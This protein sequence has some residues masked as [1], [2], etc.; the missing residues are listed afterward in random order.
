[1]DACCRMC[2]W[3]KTLNKEG[4][5]FRQG[6]QCGMLRKWFSFARSLEGTERLKTVT[7]G[8][9]RGEFEAAVTDP[10]VWEQASP[11]TILD[12]LDVL[13]EKKWGCR[14]LTKAAFPSILSIIPCLTHD[15]ISRLVK[16]THALQM[17]R[18]PVPS[19]DHTPPI[20]APHRIGGGLTT[21]SAE[22]VWNAITLRLSHGDALSVTEWV[23]LYEMFQ[24]KLATTCIDEN[25]GFAAQICRA[26]AERIPDLLLRLP[27]TQRVS[28][29]LLLIEVAGV[30][31]DASLTASLLVVLRKDLSSI[32]S[33]ST[34]NLVHVLL[35]AARHLK[36]GGQPPME[37]LR[38]GLLLVEASLRRQ[39]SASVVNESDDVDSDVL[40]AILRMPHRPQ[41]ETLVFAAFHQWKVADLDTSQVVEL[42][43]HV[44]ASAQLISVELPPQF[45][46]FITA[47]LFLSVQELDAE[48]CCDCLE[49][50]SCVEAASNA[51]MSPITSK[52]VSRFFVTFRREC[53][54]MARQ[55]DADPLRILERFACCC[56][57]HPSWGADSKSAAK[58]LLQDMSRCTWWKSGDRQSR[59]V[60][61]TWFDR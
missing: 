55:L 12:V 20:V 41:T 24:P 48:T 35:A 30:G 29:L 61:E 56:S 60:V 10:R 37:L 34:T 4:Q 2:S 51:S 46:D 5:G 39:S 13:A 36:E 50:L 26:A 45:V 21:G 1:M 38:E 54:P 40:L 42:L 43:Q 32:A 23:R 27:V 58:E 15:E 49:N 6:F 47:R 57:L 11:S 31:C 33:H 17:P 19:L 8:L 7:S 3:L 22:S 25:K 28:H 44:A 18:A 52:L 53:V 59:N 14:A 9:T 16:S